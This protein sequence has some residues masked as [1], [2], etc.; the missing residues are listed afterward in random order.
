MKTP[1]AGR[2]QTPPGTLSAPHRRCRS[3]ERHHRRATG[4]IRASAGR[5][6]AARNAGT[7]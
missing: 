2:G 4:A 6:L 5:P 3:H 7:L 1:V